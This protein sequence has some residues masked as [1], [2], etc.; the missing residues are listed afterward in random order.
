MFIYNDF[1]QHLAYC[2]I[3]EMFPCNFNHYI[4]NISTENSTSKLYLDNFITMYWEGFCDENYL[5]TKLGSE[6]CYLDFMIVEKFM[7]E[8]Q[9]TCSLD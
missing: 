1:C 8:I 9:F 5:R 4:C 7:L 2:T 3:S 6:K